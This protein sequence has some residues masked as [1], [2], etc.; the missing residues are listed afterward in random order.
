MLYGQVYVVWQD[1]SRLSITAP[2]FYRKFHTILVRSALKELHAQQAE[3]VQ[4]RAV[5][6]AANKLQRVTSRSRCN[7][8]QPTSTSGSL[9][10][11]RPESGRKG[12]FSAVQESIVRHLEPRD[13]GSA[14]PIVVLFGGGTEVH[15]YSLASALK[16]KL[17]LPDGTEVRLGHA[18]ELC[19]GMRVC[20]EQRGEGEVKSTNGTLKLVVIVF[21]RG[22]VHSYTLRSAQKLQ[23]VADDA[24]VRP[25]G[26][27]AELVAGLRVRHEQRGLG[28]IENTVGFLPPPPPP[29]LD[30][31]DE[32]EVA[33]AS[34][35]SSQE[36]AEL[37]AK[38]AKQEA[39]SKR[40]EAELEAVKHKLTHEQ[41]LR[42]EAREKIM[43]LDKKLKQIQSRSTDGGIAQKQVFL[44]HEKI[45]E[46]RSENETVKAEC[47]AKIKEV[48]AKCEET[49]AR[50]KKQQL[51]ELSVLNHWTETEEAYKRELQHVESLERQLQSTNEQTTQVEAA[52]LRLEAELAEARSQIG[53][54]QAVSEQLRS[55]REELTLALEKLEER[56][57]GEKKY[58]LQ[59]NQELLD[60]QVDAQIC[61]QQHAAAVAKLK[62]E[63]GTL[64]WASANSQNRASNL[65][66]QLSATVAGL[67]MLSVADK[68]QW[69]AHSG[70]M[71]ELVKRISSE[72]VFGWWARMLRSLAL[73]LKRKCLA[74]VARSLYRDRVSEVAAEHAKVE[75]LT[76]AT[77]QL[78]DTIEDTERHRPC[79]NQQTQV[80]EIGPREVLSGRL[81]PQLRGQLMDYPMNVSGHEWVSHVPH[82][83]FGGAGFKGT[84][85]KLQPAPVNFG[86]LPAVVPSFDARPS[87]KKV[88]TPG[89]LHHGRAQAKSGMI[90][91][92]KAGN[93][94]RPTTA[95]ARL[96]SLD[97]SA[98]QASPIP[99]RMSPL[100]H[101]DLS[102]LAH[103]RNHAASP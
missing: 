17:K 7:S 98:E 83:R 53:G 31:A 61:R 92:F 95:L 44:L 81:S 10:S 14:K 27:A 75:A 68:W 77:K 43:E 71:K 40:M 55:E 74:S 1:M 49:I 100:S 79:V 36:H 70:E 29:V 12:L 99:T 25:L 94:H 86:L 46:L 85:E 66:S 48:N 103:T 2:S 32:A 96:D 5:Q 76:T 90:I 64:K 78:I 65:E 45:D 34:N 41:S 30:G 87:R 56:L 60:A 20:H 57:A 58:I 54:A 47:A 19:V 63:I 91:S 11:I 6:G 84:W 9:L 52:R 21:D 73:Q 8:G 24:S 13:D 101:T 82:D 28:V 80:P 62:G 4:V 22:D 38:L 51:E 26:T 102:A 35:F 3:Q 69:L 42:A 93:S 18:N 39:L 15:S 88:P 67:K 50:L 97:R 16:L 59:V 33:A 37:A 89:Q 23:V 72:V